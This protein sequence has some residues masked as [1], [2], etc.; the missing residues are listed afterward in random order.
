M[1]HKPTTMVLVLEDGTEMHGTAFGKPDAVF[2]EVVFNTGMTGYVETLTDPSY[3]GQI[4]VSTYPLVGNYGVPGARAPGSLDRPYESDRIQVQ[5]LVVQSYVD[6]H[7]HHAAKRSLSQWLADEGIPAVTG[8]DEAFEVVAAGAA[9]RGVE[10]TPTEIVGLVPERFM[11]DP[12][13]KAARLLKE[14]GRSLESAL[15]GS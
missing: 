3:R 12:D 4:L 7:S 15:E 2:G 5:G 13:A 10:V 8:I 11:P 1:T 9:S 6:H 14:S